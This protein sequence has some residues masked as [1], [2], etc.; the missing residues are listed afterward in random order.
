MMI[1]VGCCCDEAKED[2]IV[3]GHQ[4]PFVKLKSYEKYST[5][6]FL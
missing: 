3:H 4:I 2:E 5:M 6:F 1:N